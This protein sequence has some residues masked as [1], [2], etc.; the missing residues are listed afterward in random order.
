MPLPD[1]DHTG[2]RI[3]AQRRLKRLTQRELADRIPY[4]L[5]LLNQVE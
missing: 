5:S 1:D 2:S 3:R 4:S